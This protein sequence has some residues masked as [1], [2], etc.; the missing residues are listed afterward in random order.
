[1]R[2][3]VVVAVV[4]IAVQHVLLEGLDRLARASALA[5]HPR[6]L[7]LLGRAL[8]VSH[9]PPPDEPAS[10]RADGPRPAS[11]TRYGPPSAPPAGRS[12]ARRRVRPGSAAWPRAAPRTRG[13]PR[14]GPSPSP[15]A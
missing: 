9:A 2:H 13:S 15:R 3:L 1:Q 14:S 6:R 10:S 4:V 12:D 8:A 11:P 5:V 7:A